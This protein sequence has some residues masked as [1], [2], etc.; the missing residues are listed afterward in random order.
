MYGPQGGVSELTP[1]TTKRPCL[2][3]KY[4][5]VFDMDVSKN[6]GTPKSSILIRFSIVNHPFWSTLIFGNAHRDPAI[7]VYKFYLHITG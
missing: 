7:M 3:L 5:L 1:K 6:R 2:P 4:R